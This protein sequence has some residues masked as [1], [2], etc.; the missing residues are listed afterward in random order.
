M[1]LDNKEISL[2]NRETLQDWIK[3][4]YNENIIIYT[5]DYTNNGLDKSFCFEKINLTVCFKKTNI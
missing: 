3:K 1:L 2:M 5:Y 4:Y